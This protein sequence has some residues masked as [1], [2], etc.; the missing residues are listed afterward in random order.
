MN[1]LIFKL[2]NLKKNPMSYTKRIISGEIPTLNIFM[3]FGIEKKNMIQYCVKNIFTR[4]KFQNCLEL[5]IKKILTN[6]FSD[7]FNNIFR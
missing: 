4:L 6:N 2:P 1:A 3:K 5:D 7:I